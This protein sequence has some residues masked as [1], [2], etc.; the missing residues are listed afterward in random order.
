MYKYRAV[1]LV[2]KTL[3]PDQD[4]HRDLHS[5]FDLKF[6]IPIRIHHTETN[7]DPQYR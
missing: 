3:D 2:I 7:A 5:A 4:L 6:W 1:L